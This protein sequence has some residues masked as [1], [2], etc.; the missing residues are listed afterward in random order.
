MFLCK[1]FLFN[2]IKKAFPVLFTNKNN[3]EFPDFT[4]LDQCNG[5]KK[6]IECSKTARQNNKTL[7]ILHEHHFSDKE[8]IE[9]DQLISINERIG[10][11]LKRKVDIYTDRF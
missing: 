7:G 6:F 10:A 2:P 8:M 9:C 5:F 3:G 1:H 4:G 11:L